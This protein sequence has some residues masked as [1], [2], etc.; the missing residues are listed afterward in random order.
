MH[1][2][3]NYFL[4][5]Y[6]GSEFLIAVFVKTQNFIILFDFHH[7]KFFQFCLTATS[8]YNISLY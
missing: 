6:P 2:N 7:E 3:T 4:T 8:T 5:I 1:D